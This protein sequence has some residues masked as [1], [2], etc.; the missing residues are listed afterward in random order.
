[1]SLQLE[2]DEKT[3]DHSLKGSKLRVTDST[4][5]SIQTPLSS[6]I[7]MSP[8]RFLSKTHNNSSVDRV[9]RRKKYAI[10]GNGFETLQPQSKPFN[11]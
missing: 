1:M 5:H 11:L 8:G 9:V 6:L 2:T 4:Q 7:S 10:K 3:P